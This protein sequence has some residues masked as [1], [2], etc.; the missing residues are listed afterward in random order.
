MI[1]RI[2]VDEQGRAW[3]R[4]TNAQGAV[5][6]DIYGSDG[7][8]MATADLGPHRSPSFLPFMVRGDNVYMVV[9]DEDDVQHVARFQIE[10]R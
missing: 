6:F 7:R 2:T 8:L 1:D 5:A 9:L 3:I 10:H 4:R